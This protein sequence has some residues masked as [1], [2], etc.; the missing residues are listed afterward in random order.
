MLKYPLHFVDVETTS[1]DVKRGEIISIAIITENEAGESSIFYSLI[2][3]QKLIMAD[4]V[5][6]RIAKYSDERWKHAPKFEEIA[7]LVYETLKEG[8]LIAHNAQFDEG[9]IKHAINKHIG[10]ELGRKNITHRILCTRQLM[11]EHSPTKR[12]SLQTAREL[13]GLHHLEAHDA[14]DDAKACR[15][16]FHELFQCSALKRAWL[17]FKHLLKRNSHHTR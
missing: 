14:L 4:E 6:L 7:R 16:V 13:F 17:R 8:T 12:T 15:H 10:K 1:L 11:M 3:P 2:K 9:F 5:S